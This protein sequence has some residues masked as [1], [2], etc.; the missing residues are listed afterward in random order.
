M[1]SRGPASAHLAL[2][3]VQVCFGLFPIAAKFAFR[4]GA[5]TPF[6]LTLWRILFGAGSLLAAALLLHGRA[7]L[8]RPRDLG[9]LALCSFL[10]ITA[11]MVLYLEGLSRSTAT[12]AGLMI[13]LIPV[14][15]FVVAL[16]ARQERF[17]RLR[18]L[19]V[20]VALAGA[21]PLL[22]SGGPELGPE[23]ALG[24]SL[25][26]LNTLSYA[27]FLVLSRPLLERYAPLV[28]IAWVFALAIPFAPL[29][30]RGGA[31]VPDASAE[32]WW[33]FAFVL[34]FPT[35]VAYFLNAFALARLRAS[36]IATYVYAQPLITGLGGRFLLGEKLT[37]GTA[38]SAGCVFLGIWLV[39]RGRVR[40]AVHC[41]CGA[42]LF[43]S[44]RFCAQCGRAVDAS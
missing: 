27:I 43:W 38:L 20:L 24:N 25:M 18:A 26:V 35:S 42:P 12:N 41:E 37:R 21:A 32:A 17:H 6:T 22:L 2:A 34:V 1:A 4:D 40:E 11:N 44:A 31:H 5:F 13:C 15:T 10:G 36:T 8:P 28:V 9:M 14:F 7:A 39:S 19:G 30:A 29:L 3:V 33:A 16:I 23:H